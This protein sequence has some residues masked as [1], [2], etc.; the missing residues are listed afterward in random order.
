MLCGIDVE[1]LDPGVECAAGSS[2]DEGRGVAIMR[3]VSV[4]ECE[5][6]NIMRCIEPRK[7]KVGYSY[8]PATLSGIAAVP[9]GTCLHCRI[10]QANH[11]KVRLLMERLCHDSSSFVT[12]TYDD[13]HLPHPPHVKKKELTKFIK[14]IR[15]N[16]GEYKVRYF[17]VGEYGDKS[18][19]PHYHAVLFGLDSIIHKNLIHRC[20]KKCDPKVGIKI[21]EFNKERAG[22]ITGYIKKKVLKLNGVHPTNYNKTDEFM[23]A[24]RRPGIGKPFIDKMV[25]VLGKDKRIRDQ[26]IDTARI[27]GRKEALGRYC[28]EHINKW[29]SLGF[30]LKLLRFAKTQLEYDTLRQFRLHDYD[31]RCQI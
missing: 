5:D 4:G 19:R 13:K 2:E 17:G 14:R 31:R 11:W 27:N 26:F 6:N 21:D 10:D 12:L 22:Y 16:T 15:N 30:N 1:D 28:K 8:A 23:L 20:W 3:V 18:F 24:S 9:C 7:V 29:Q 25:E